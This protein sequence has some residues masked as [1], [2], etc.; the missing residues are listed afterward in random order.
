MPIEG[1]A[2]RRRQ[3]LVGLSALLAGAA[4]PGLA[5][6]EEP[7]RAAAVFLVAAPQ[8]ADPNFRESVVLVTHHGGGGPVGLIINKPTPVPLKQVFPGN[9]ALRDSREPVFFGGP[10]SRR[11][12]VFVFR[13]AEAPANGVR[14]LD[15]LYMSFDPALL[16]ELLARPRPLQDIRVFAGYAG[17]APGQ[18]QREIGR[19]DWLL[20]RPDA[21]SVFHQAPERMWQ[22][23][24][25]RAS[26]REV[27]AP[28]ATTPRPYA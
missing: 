9:A 17:W 12:L 4:L 14:L 7:D 15:D 6:T 11:M 28:P 13:A 18:L 20:L 21:E 1:P 22:Q 16:R 2:R 25:A 19:G 27:R 23:M 3:V 24:R 26:A 8:L 5:R 10:V